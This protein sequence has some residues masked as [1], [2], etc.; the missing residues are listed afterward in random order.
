MKCGFMMQQAKQNV[1]AANG[2]NDW[3][4]IL[5]LVFVR[6]CF[7]AERSSTTRLEIEF[8]SQPLCKHL[9]PFPLHPNGEFFLA[10]P[11]LIRGLMVTG[12]AW[13]YWDGLGFVSAGT[14]TH[15]CR[16]ECMQPPRH[17]APIHTY[18]SLTCCLLLYFIP[19]TTLQH[20][21][22]TVQF[23]QCS[24]LSIIDTHLVF[25]AKG[26]EVDAFTKQFVRDCFLQSSIESYHCQLRGARHMLKLCKHGQ[27]QTVHS[28][29]YVINNV[30]QTALTLITVCNQQ[31]TLKCK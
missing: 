11:Q 2:S 9:Q 24:Y 17:W 23:I 26:I 15:T 20:R 7:E 16:L 28:I 25:I 12:R 19:L 27:G 1:S 5:L 21:E 3:E 13:N 4:C 29:C 18:P 31:N 30:I 8:K 6:G 10:G 22:K 14:S